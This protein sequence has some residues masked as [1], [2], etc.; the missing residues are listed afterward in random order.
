MSAIRMPEQGQ[1]AA[2][3]QV[4]LTKYIVV[5]YNSQLLTDDRRWNI[6]RAGQDRIP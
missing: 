3:R 1:P 6:K 5:H 2:A 4:I